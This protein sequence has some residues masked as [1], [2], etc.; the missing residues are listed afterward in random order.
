MPVLPLVA[1]MTV[2]PGFSSPRLLGALDDGARHAVLDRAH[3]IERLDLDVDVHARRRELAEPHERRVADR[4]EDVVVA[5]HRVSPRGRFV[6][7]RMLAADRWQRPCETTVVFASA[8]R[9]M[10]H[11][12]ALAGAAGWNYNRARW[13]RCDSSFSAISRSLADGE[14]LALPPSRKTRALLA[15][16]AL[17]GARVPPR[18]PV[19]AALGDPRRPARLAALEPV[20]AAP[21]RRRRDARAHRRRPAR[22]RAS[23][24]PTSTIDVAALQR[25]WRK[26]SST[27]RPLEELEAAAAR[28]C[29]TPL[30]GLELPTFHDYSRVVH[31][32]A[33]ARDA[34][35]DAP[36]ERAAAAPRR[37]PAARRSPHART[38]VRI[39]PYD[40]KARAALIR[41]LV[42]L[43]RPDQAEQQ[44]ELGSRLLKEAGATPTGELLRAWRGA[45]RGATGT[46]SS[47]I[48]GAAAGDAATARG[49]RTSPARRRGRTQCAGVAEPRSSAATPSSTRL[50]RA[51]R[52]RIGAAPLPRRA[53]ARRARHRQEP[54]ARGGRRPRPRSGRRRARGERPT[55]SESIRPFALWIDALRKL[56]P[57]RG[58][59]SLRPRRSRRTA[60]GFFE[61]LERAHR[62]SARARSPSC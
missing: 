34:R 52:G 56:E 23:T 15:Y 61:R 51:L 1:S 46:R 35:A 11:G 4:L 26:G 41:L 21:A 53:A 25:R 55:K 32:R 37:R 13:P 18:A 17:N 8:G 31:R 47:R 54:P 43:G 3:R 12:R 57:D 19:R 38:L 10:Q 62:R 59:R 2:W 7:G 36:A 20:E 14:R 58:Y 49:R 27:T 28:Y 42:A 16:L 50:R 30:E 40:E 6:V 39:A 9:G 29:G 45:P 24:R 5:G 22:R 48:A 60:I 44:Y 33:R